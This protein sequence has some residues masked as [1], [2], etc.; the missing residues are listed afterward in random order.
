MS[1]FTV[2]VVG[3]D[4]EEILNP[5][6]E[7]DLDREALRK[8]HRAVFD[9]EI[10]DGVN[11]AGISYLEA[12][13]LAFL[14]RKDGTRKEYKDAAAWLQ[15]WH[16]Y[17]YQPGLGYGYWR[18]PNAKW[19]WYQVG[20]R[21]IGALIL[22]DGVK[23][24]LGEPSWMVQL[25]KEGIPENRSDMARI[26]DVDWKA[27]R[28]QARERAARDWD[29]LFNP[30]PEFCLY[31][32]EYVESQRALHLKLYGT[33]EEYIRRRGVWTPYAMVSKEHGWIA[34]GKMGWFGMSTDNTH[35]REKFDA[36]F[37]KIMKSFPTETQ[38]AMV[39]C[40]I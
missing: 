18:N 21:W 33:K 19:D 39:D 14:I 31:R 30:N 1:H 3:N 35:D 29:E 34:P 38:I 6:W 11:G 10:P 26:C 4:V 2:L 17:D 36:E 23:A 37:V 20:G 8:D 24:Q 13:Y 9:V 27:M 12:E 40:H 15:D 22:K 5:Y 25:P 28:N 32:P 7:L 16:G